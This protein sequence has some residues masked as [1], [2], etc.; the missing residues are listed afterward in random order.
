MSRA[1]RVDCYFPWICHKLLVHLLGRL[2]AAIG[3]GILAFACLIFTL[4]S[5]LRYTIPRFHLPVF[6]DRKDLLVVVPVWLVASGLGGLFLFTAS[7]PGRASREWRGQSNKMRLEPSR[8]V[9]LQG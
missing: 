5:D 7:S 3:R 6:L 8:R 2:L 4:S 9:C 1:H